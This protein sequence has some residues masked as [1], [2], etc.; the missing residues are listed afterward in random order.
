MHRSHLAS[1][2]ADPH[3]FSRRIVGCNGARNEGSDE[4]IWLGD[5]TSHVVCGRLYLPL[6]ERELCASL[7]PYDG[8]F[9]HLI[10][11]APAPT[12]IALTFEDLSSLCFRKCRS[13]MMSPMT[14]LMT[15][16]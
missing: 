3:G 6:H 4:R 13:P 1:L 9:A 12:I 8:S 14:F 7:P 15:K 10:N 11:P 5:K 16:R 2:S